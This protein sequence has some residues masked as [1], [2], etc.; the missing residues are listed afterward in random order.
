MKIVYFLEKLVH[1]PEK[2]IVW[3][4]SNKIT[5]ATDD[6]KVP[7]CGNVGDSLRQRPDLRAGRPTWPE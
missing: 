3:L 1:T 2:K 6:T 5:T 4:T 7:E